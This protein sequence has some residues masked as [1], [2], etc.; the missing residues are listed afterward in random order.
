MEEF[1]PPKAKALSEF[2]LLKKLETFP[3]DD[4]GLKA[5]EA[6]IAQQRQLRAQ[7]QLALEA[8]IEAA[9][10]SNDPQRRKALLDFVGEALPG[11]VPAPE[12]PE[13]VLTSEIS[14]VTRKSRSKVRSRLSALIV[15]LASGLTVGIV[16]AAALLMLQF[17][18]LSAGVGAA[19]GLVLGWV[20]TTMLKS[21]ALHPVLRA[22][23]VFGG[24]GVYLFGGLALSIPALLL[25]AELP[26]GSSYSAA[27]LGFYPAVAVLVVT[28]G[29]L[30][31]QLIPRR[32]FFWILLALGIGSLATFP[33]FM[34]PGRLAF[35]LDQALPAFGVAVFVS[36]VARL[37]MQP[38]IN[39]G[40][41][42][43]ASSAGIAIATSAGLLVF[44]VANDLALIAAGLVLVVA[45]SLSGRDLAE[46]IV[47]RWAGLA[48]LAG[49]MLAPIATE[50]ALS[51]ALVLTTASLLLILDQL[52]RRS[53]LHIASLDTSY[54]FYGAF[55]FTAW[56]A[57]VLSGIS[58]YLPDLLGFTLSVEIHFGIAAG[59]GLI[60]GLLRAP[61][62]FRQDRE[63]K[64]AGSD[65]GA[66]ENLLGL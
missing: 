2:E 43:Q 11:S 25:V 48:P 49:L 13:A 37:F 21:H 51:A 28:L 53:S 4:A 30:I 60:F 22:A 65:R 29:V 10:A 44:A 64:L 8:W 59:L 3:S 40:A 23:T 41:L 57:L 63:I 47:G 38:H 62:V 35:E 50:V 58:A 5:A 55:G 24:R 61:I 34:Q 31:G 7:D 46:S 14:V 42:G 1:E 17:S 66:L 9:R 39:T 19:A 32:L 54:G 36:V 27:M 12:E 52:F 26:A 56:A 33:P 20:A 16:L 45:L 18:G 6:L 15:N